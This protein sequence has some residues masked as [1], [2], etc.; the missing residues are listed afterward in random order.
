MNYRNETIS[1]EGVLDINIGDGLLQL[2]TEDC[3]Y[4]DLDEILREF[5]GQFI[6]ITISKD[7]KIVYMR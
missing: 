5:D 2:N 7:K 3:G 4:I 1:L 6:S